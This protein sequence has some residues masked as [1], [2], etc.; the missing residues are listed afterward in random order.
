MRTVHKINKK[1]CSARHSRHTRPRNWNIFSQTLLRY[2]RLVA[3]AVHLSSVTLYTVGRDM[4]VSAIFLHRLIAQ[5]LGQFVLKFW[6][7]LRRD[8]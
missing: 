4:N 7:K 8:S 5:G 6:A 2:V 1:L 3:W